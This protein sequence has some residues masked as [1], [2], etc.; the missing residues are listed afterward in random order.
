MMTWIPIAFET[1][2]SA[3]HSISV[4]RLGASSSR[5]SRHIEPAAGCALSTPSISRSHARSRELTGSRS[6]SLCASLSLSRTEAQTLHA[7][8]EGLRA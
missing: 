2:M 5:P 8:A 1:Q 3:S 4:F 6:R 7:V